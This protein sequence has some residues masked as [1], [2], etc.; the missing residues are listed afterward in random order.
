MGSC[1]EFII[2]SFNVS[3]Y[4]VE[5]S[6]GRHVRKR[7]A[8]ISRRFDVRFFHSR[9]SLHSLS[10]DSPTLEEKW[11]GTVDLRLP[12]EGLGRRLNIL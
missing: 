6:V 4:L 8:S 12:N 7:G 5:G 2:P 3:S 10:A 1:S 11:K 9:R